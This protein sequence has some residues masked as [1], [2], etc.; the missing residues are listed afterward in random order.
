MLILSRK[1][2][3]ELVIGDNIRLTVV[4][5][6]G[7]QVR[8]GITVPVEMPVQPQELCRSAPGAIGRI[9]WRRT[10]RPDVQARQGRQ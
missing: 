2:G 6:R 1:P 5:I 10:K 8:L 3:E 4:A 9:F 7:K